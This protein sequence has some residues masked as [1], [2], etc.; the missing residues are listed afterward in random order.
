MGVTAHD[1]HAR[2]GN[3]ELRANGVNDALLSVTHR[4]QSNT[5]LLAVLAQGGNL[6]TGY[7]VLNLQQ[8]TGLDTHCRNVMIFG[9]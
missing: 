8:V 6:G 4:M 2:L 1:G 9:G 5:K 7:L 3:A